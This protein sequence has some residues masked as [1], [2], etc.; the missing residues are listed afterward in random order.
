MS[1]IY[2]NMVGGSSGSSVAVDAT[3]SV[4]GQ[5]ADAKAV[6]DVI[7]SLSDGKADLSVVE[8]ALSE[9][10]TDVAALVGGDA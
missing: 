4:S 3:L 9:Y 2:G 7:K 5:A 6:G 8:S 10:I 1:V